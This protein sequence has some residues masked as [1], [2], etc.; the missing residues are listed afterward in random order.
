M[1]EA[2]KMQN[3]GERQQFTWTD[4]IVD[5]LLVTYVK[6][7]RNLERKSFSKLQMTLIKLT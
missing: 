6:I 7:M 5:A 3:T 4:K 1:A 2:I